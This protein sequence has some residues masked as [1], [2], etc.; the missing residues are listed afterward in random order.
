VS[1]DTRPAYGRAQLETLYARLEKRIYN[2]VYRWVWNEQEA[3]DVTQEAFLR[4]WKMRE[5]I[6][7]A[8]VEPL[9]FR[10]AVNVAASRRR[11]RKLRSFIG[12]G[13]TLLADP[14]PGPEAAS[15]RARVRG[16]IEALPE[17][18]R[19]V[20]VMTELSELSYEEVAAALSIPVGTVGSR[21]SA[22]LA[23]LKRALS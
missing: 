1:E 7:P 4:L 8:T 10:I 14:G 17:K 2:V 9:A 16:A 23:A 18:L 21:R 6:E 3:M 13:E 12:L 15:E 19:K 20:I 22:G 5:R 11:A